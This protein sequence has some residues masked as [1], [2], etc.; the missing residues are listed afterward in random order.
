MKVWLLLVSI[1]TTDGTIIQYIGVPPA[2]ANT[3][4][5]C[6]KT[7]ARMFKKYETAPGVV[8]VKAE[9]GVMDVSKYLGQPI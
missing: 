9:C 7:R 2:N 1:Y 6:E 3:E 4:Q 8:R 5:A